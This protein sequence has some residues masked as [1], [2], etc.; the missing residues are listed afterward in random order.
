MPLK[1]KASLDDSDF[2]A[3]LRSMEAGVKSASAKMST[4]FSAIGAVGGAFGATALIGTITNIGERFGNIKDQAASIDLP[5]EEFQRLGFALS[6]SGVGAETFQKGM[7]SLTDSFVKARDATTAQAKAMEV[8]GVSLSNTNESDATN[9]LA[10]IADAY[11]NSADKGAAFAAISDLVGA[12]VAV[13]LVPALVDGGAELRRLAA[14]ADIASEEMVLL[15][16]S[17]G[18]KID[19]FK[20]SLS[21]RMAG[22]AFGLGEKFVQ[23]FKDGAKWGEDL[24]LPKWLAT[25]TGV[26]SAAHKGA[27][28]VVGMDDEEG[29]DPEMLKKLDAQNAEKAAKQQAITEAQKQFE[30]KSIDEV[31]EHERKQYN[32]FTEFERKRIEDIH[33]TERRQYSDF[34]GFREDQEEKL[35]QKK[36]QLAKERQSQDLQNLKELETKINQQVATMNSVRT[37]MAAEIRADPHHFAA[38]AKREQNAQNRA[39]NKADRLAG[40]TPDDRKKINEVQSM[41][42]GKVKENEAKISEQSIT[43]LVAEIGKLLHG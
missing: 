25:I 24:G 19:A 1:F 38:N 21:N 14:S 42:S 37:G 34:I 33:E 17:M 28:A 2:Q 41:V 32:E 26:Y 36:D 20:N 5:I 22:N 12:K 8:L 40:I 39:E 13:K 10:N 4:A 3:R 18:D 30:K 11:V 31:R 7:A 27:K 9:A 43:R 16:E 15:S 29:S 35:A 6:Q 23:G